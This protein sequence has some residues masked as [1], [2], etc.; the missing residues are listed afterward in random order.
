MLRDLRNGAAH[1]DVDDVGA[2]ALDDL[3]RR[4]HF[5]GIAAEDLDRYRPL[6]FGV[7]RVFE[8]AIDAAHEPL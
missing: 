3:R 5:F 7:L 1:I 6:L 4:R 8:R 2:H